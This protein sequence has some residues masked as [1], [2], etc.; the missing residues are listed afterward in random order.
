MSQVTKARTENI[1]GHGCQFGLDL[2]QIST[3]FTLLISKSAAL[4]HCGLWTLTYW[5]ESP[6]VCQ[7]NHSAYQIFA[8]NLGLC[9]MWSEQFCSTLLCPMC[10]CG[11]RTD[12]T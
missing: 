3:L 11:L 5:P 9:L 1:F 10:P 4:A 2:V 8:Q 6:T 12:S 7:I